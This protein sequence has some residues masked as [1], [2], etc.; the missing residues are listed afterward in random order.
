M[1]QEQ[2][3]ICMRRGC[4][5]HCWERGRGS[6]TVAR[7]EELPTG[8]IVLSVCKKGF[9]I[10]KL[11]NSGLPGGLICFIEDLRAIQTVI[12]VRR[13]KTTIMKL[14]ETVPKSGLSSDIRIVIQYLDCHLTSGLSS[15][16]RI[17]TSHLDCYPTYGLPPVIWTVIQHPNC[18]PTSG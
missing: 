1:D 14:D 3:E 5:V 13:T 16:I 10:E 17:A 9:R 4:C 7:I 15:N 6:V 2:D 12:R 18:H 8:Q 11:F